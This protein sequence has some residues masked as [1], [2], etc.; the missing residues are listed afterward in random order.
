MC[1]FLFLFFFLRCLLKKIELTVNPELQ[2]EANKPRSG[3]SK[4]ASKQS[5]VRLRAVTKVHTTNE[6]KPAVSDLI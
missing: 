2:A 3:G 1:C 4:L 5:E 6:S